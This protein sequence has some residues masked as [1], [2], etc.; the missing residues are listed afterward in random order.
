MIL[1]FIHVESLISSPSRGS[2]CKGFDIIKD[3]QTV[4]SDFIFQTERVSFVSI[5]R[6]DW[7]KVFEK[8]KLHGKNAMN[9]TYVFHL[10]TIGSFG[11]P[12][13]STV[14]YGFFNFL[15]L[16]SFWEADNKVCLK[17]VS[18]PLSSLC[19]YHSTL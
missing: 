3:H 10:N 16:C 11:I 14:Q 12:F 15:W 1:I 5:S 13:A 4:L 17:F 2:I 9:G 19:F 18:F 6:H 7:K 8:E